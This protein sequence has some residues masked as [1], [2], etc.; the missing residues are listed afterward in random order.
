MARKEPNAPP[1]VIMFKALVS[2]RMRDMWVRFFPGW[3]MNTIAIRL[4]MLWLM[5]SRNGDFRRK[6][7]R[8]AQLLKETG[9]N[10]PEDHGVNYFP[11]VPTSEQESIESVWPAA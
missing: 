1:D 9:N 11:S 4:V 2:R 7:Q 6:I 3:G 10:F 8:R 5:D